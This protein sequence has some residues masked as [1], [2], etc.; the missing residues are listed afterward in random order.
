MPLIGMAGATILADG[1]WLYLHHG[2]HQALFRDVQ[3]APLQVRWIPALLVYVVILAAV[4]YFAVVP[5]KSTIEALKKGALLGFAMYGLY[6]L[7]KYATLTNYSFTM[8]FSDM[9]WGTFLCALVAGT[10]Y[11]LRKQ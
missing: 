6:D 10:G 5:S 2:Y 7:T 1:V 9:A 4:Y 3:Q 8:T 11:Y